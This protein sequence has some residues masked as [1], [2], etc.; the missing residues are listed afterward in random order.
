MK[1]VVG[2]SRIRVE[3]VKAAAAAIMVHRKCGGGR[4]MLV[5]VSFLRRQSQRIDLDAGG[6]GR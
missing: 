4:E 6:L 1:A 3:E 5:P 2:S